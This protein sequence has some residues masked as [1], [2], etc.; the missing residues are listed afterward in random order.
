MLVDDTLLVQLPEDCRPA[1]V[2]VEFLRLTFEDDLLRL[3]EPLPVLVAVHGVEPP[4]GGGD[5]PDAEVVEHVLELLEVLRSALR[6]CVAPVEEGVD[7]DLR[8]AGAFRGIEKGIEVLRMAVD[9]ARRDEPVGVE[10]GVVR[11]HV[12]EEFHECGIR[13]ELILADRLADA[14]EVGVDGRAGADGHV[15][16]LAVAH[17]SLREADG[18][19]AR[20]EE[21]MRVLRH[22]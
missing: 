13:P 16:D 19:A 14:D 4:R 15:A 2:L 9:A 5:E 7:G 22:E 8:Y 18:W 3:R 12:F 17:L 1:P 6:R 11:L 20:I 21:R 10:Y